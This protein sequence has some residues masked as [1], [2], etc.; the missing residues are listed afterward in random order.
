MAT[1]L[2]PLQCPKRLDSG[3]K[4]LIASGDIVFR[5]VFL[6]RLSV[7][8]SAPKK[9]FADSL[10]QGKFRRASLGGICCFIGL[11]GRQ[12]PTPC[13]NSPTLNIANAQQSLCLSVFV[14]GI[15]E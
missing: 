10:G 2:L 13:R 4:Q 5:K 12:G 11:N 1:C 14:V 8:V 3:F 6:G 7:V 15:F 9:N